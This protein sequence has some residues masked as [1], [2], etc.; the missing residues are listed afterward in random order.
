MP[1]LTAE[2][3]QAHQE[4]LGSSEAGAALGLNPW[5]SPLALY[6][7]KVGEVVPDDL[8]DN[9]AVHFG[10]VL[11]DTIAQEYMRRSGCRVRRR[12]QT[13][14]HSEHPFM[15]AHPDRTID[16]EKTILECKTAGAWA[17]NDWGPDGSDQVPD[18]YVV[19]VHHQMICMDYPQA[20]LAVLIGGRDFRTYRFERDFEMDRLIIDGECSFWYDHV[21]KHVPPEPS[22]VEDLSYL[23]D[24]GT[25]ITA[26]SDIQALAQALKTVRGELKDLEDQK[27]SLEVSI[28]KFM[29]E[30]STLLD[31]NGLPLATW[32]QAKDSQRFDAKALQKD[33]PELYAQYLKTTAGSRRLLLK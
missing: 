9:A 13:F 32:K 27:K 18:Q 7:E 19:Q 6:L 3:L 33:N 17:Q 16:G 8:T 14:H 10:N 4:G 29:G 24:A 2:Q 23:R 5:K 25:S 1:P 30:N 28:K 15:V 26:D 31:A 21:Q 12:N 22:T 20:V 11:E